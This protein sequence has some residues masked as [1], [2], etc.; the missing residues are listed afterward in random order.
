M[1]EEGRKLIVL[2]NDYGRRHFAKPVVV[3]RCAFDL[4]S[5]EH[6]DACEKAFIQFERILRERTD[7]EVK[8]EWANVYRCGLTVTFDVHWYDYKFFENRKNAYRVGPHAF[9]FQRFG[10]V[11]D[12]F[13]IVHEVMNI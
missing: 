10:A 2:G 13:K 8:Y 4:K 11:A 9:A 5:S 12:D 7:D 6:I 3:S 1:N